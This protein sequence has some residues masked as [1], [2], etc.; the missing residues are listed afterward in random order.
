MSRYIYR[1]LSD[2]AFVFL[3][4]AVLVL[5]YKLGYD[6]LP[7]KLVCLTGFHKYFTSFIIK[8]DHILYI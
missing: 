5:C 1:M 7:K 4:V 8:T 6:S 3:K 2:T